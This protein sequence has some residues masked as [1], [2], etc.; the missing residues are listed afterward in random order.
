MRFPRTKGLITSPAIDLIRKLLRE[1]EG[2][3]CSNKYRVNDYELRKATSGYP[4]EVPVNRLMKDYAGHYVYPDDATDLK[5]HPFF[6]QIEWELIHTKKP[7][8]IPKVKSWE[9]TK[10]F[11]EEE[12][13]SDVSDSSSYSSAREDPDPDPAAET[14]ESATTACAPHPENTWNA[15]EIRL[16]SEVV[17]DKMKAKQAQ[18]DNKN[19]VAKKEKKRPR[20]MLLRDPE[21]GRK[22]LEIRKKGAFM[23]YTYR[24][25][26]GFLWQ[27]EEERLGRKVGNERG[28]LPSVF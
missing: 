25:P 6:R 13:I 17:K 19:K 3:L 20:D 15:N 2:R 4:R 26:H 21:V 7:P 12:P 8:F 10:Y 22:V 24:R 14:D 27:G 1:K 18:D 5:K 16:V 23:G 28:R 11:E 9:D